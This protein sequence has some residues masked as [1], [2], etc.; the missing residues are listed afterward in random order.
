MMPY[1]AEQYVEISKRLN[2]KVPHRL[3]TPTVSQIIADKITCRPCPRWRTIPLPTMTAQEEQAQGADS[4]P[5]VQDMSFP[6]P[7]S[8]VP[9]SSCYARESQSPTLPEIVVQSRV[10]VTSAYLSDSAPGMPGAWQ[11]V[12]MNAQVGKSPFAERPM[13]SSRFPVTPSPLALQVE[14][15]SLVLRRAELAVVHAVLADWEGGVLRQSSGRVRR[16]RRVCGA[17]SCLFY[18]SFSLVLHTRRVILLF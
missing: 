10:S 11:T 6:A 7:P 3:D 4:L 13:G 17:C 12:F 9:T 15:L 8:P 14:V 1:Q 18:T 16:V 5:M 2:N